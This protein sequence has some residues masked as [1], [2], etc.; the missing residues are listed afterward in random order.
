M[1]EEQRNKDRR[2]NIVVLIQK[3][4]LN[5]GFIDSVTKL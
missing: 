3:Y 1:N 4:L 2:R 5:L